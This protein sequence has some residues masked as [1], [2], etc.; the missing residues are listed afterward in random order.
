[1]PVA[2]F[3]RQPP[4][5]VAT[6][7]V[8]LRTALKDANSCCIDA[9]AAARLCQFLSFLPLPEPGAGLAIEYLA[10]PAGDRC[11]AA[12][13]EG[14]GKRRSAVPAGKGPCRAAGRPA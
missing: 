13:K 5:L 7:D 6:F 1:M 9:G 14:T 11:A 8:H 12:G 2:A 4:C 10:G 3:P